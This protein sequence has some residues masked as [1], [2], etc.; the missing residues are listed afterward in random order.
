MTSYF[1]R[2]KHRA[3]TNNARNLAAVTV[4]AG[5]AFGGVSTLGNTP[6]NAEPPG[7]WGP[8]I[9]CES[10]NKNVENPSPESSASGYFQFIDSTWRENGGAQFASR[11]I[12]ASFEEQLTIANKVFAKSGLTPWNASRSCWSGRV[13]PTPSATTS[14]NARQR[15]AQR[16]AQA[17]QEAGPTHVVRSG[18]T[19]SKIAGKH[20]K[21]VYENNKG[22][23]GSNPDRIFPGQ[24]IRL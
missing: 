3:P 6:A 14:K 7:G 5:L 20:W 12:G 16:L 18:D 22:T 21:S 11:A 15:T 19:L 13:G 23:I 9:Q 1:Y 10:S 24:I 8:V 2:G 4:G 17:H